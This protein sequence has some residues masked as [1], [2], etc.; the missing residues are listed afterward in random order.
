M[1]GINGKA[2]DDVKS[3]DIKLILER[4]NGEDSI[5][6]ESTFFEWKADKESS[7]KLAKEICAFLDKLLVEKIWSESN[8]K[9]YI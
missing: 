7:S 6:D 3:S 2:W 1:I 4:I 5:F 9:K 8:H